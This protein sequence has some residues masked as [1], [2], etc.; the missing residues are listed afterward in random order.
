MLLHG[1]VVDVMFSS[2]LVS[3]LHLL[4]DF[5]KVSNPNYFIIVR[6]CS[7][8]SKT[9]G[10]VYICNVHGLFE[11]HGLIEFRGLFE[12]HKLFE[13]QGLFKI[14]GLFELHGLLD[15]LSC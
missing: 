6:E 8:R 4:F 1:C 3:V 12:F 9:G 7:I 15:S 14:H 10:R 11:F 2:G 5:D 13:F